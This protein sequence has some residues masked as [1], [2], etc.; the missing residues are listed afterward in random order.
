VY[1][2]ES[3]RER[4]RDRI[5][6]LHSEGKVESMVLEWKEKMNVFLFRSQ[7]IV[8]PVKNVFF[9]VTFNVLAKKS[10]GIKT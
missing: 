10:H 9:S 6:I 2:C 4:E 3:E 7:G 5:D 8:D 1:V